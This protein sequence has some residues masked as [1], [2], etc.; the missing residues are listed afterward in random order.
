M[1]PA[2]IFAKNLRP[3]AMELKLPGADERLVSTSQLAWCL[4]LLQNSRSSDEALEPTVQLWLKTVEKDTEEQDRLQTIATEVINAFKRDESKDTKA[5]AEVTQLAPV[6]G[7]TVFRDLL[8]EIYTWIEHAGSLDVHHLEVFVQLIKGAEPDHLC[9]G[10]LVKILELLCNRLGDTHQ[11]STPNMCLLAL[12]VSRVLD[13][14]VDTKVTDPDLKALHEPLASYLTKLK[15]NLDPYLVYQ[16]AYTFQA[17]LC[18]PD[19]EV[20]WQTNQR[21]AKNVALGTTGLSS[22]KKSMDLDRFFGDLEGIQK[23]LAGTCVITDLVNTTYD[24]VVYLTEFGLGQGIQDSL[25]LNRSFERK[26]AWYSALRGADALIQ[27]GELASF[28][29]LVCEAPCRLDPA[30]QWG[31]CQRLGEIAANPM[32]DTDTRRGAIAFLGEIYK[33]DDVW[34]QQASVRQ[35]ILNILMQMASLSGTG[36]QCMWEFSE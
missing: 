16:A 29:K 24:D 12:G 36:L 19:N 27:D 17:L 4:S 21:R 10:D 7:K 20:A 9:A 18:V 5:F 34:G 2:H 15:E 30:F 8:T 11:Q 26:C 35:W 31:V 22:A 13:A 6:L 28:R 33:N 23:G 32:W 25:K 1:V 14:M 3:L